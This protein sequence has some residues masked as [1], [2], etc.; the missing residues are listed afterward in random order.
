MSDL[1]SDMSDLDR[2]CPGWRSDMSGHQKF[3]AAE[4]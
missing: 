2:I 3:R 1:R 4:K